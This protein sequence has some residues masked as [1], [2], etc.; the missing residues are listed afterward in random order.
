MP[1]SYA[2]SLLILALAHAGL[3]QADNAVAAGCA[4]LD[5]APLVWP[6]MVLA[7]KLDETLTRGFG[8]VTDTA[9]YH[10]R[11]V[12]AVS[13]TAARRQLPTQPEDRG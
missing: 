10:A 2:R 5:S 11:Y 9:D 13:R 7:G 8:G 1:S 4:A 6:T 12:D 3:G